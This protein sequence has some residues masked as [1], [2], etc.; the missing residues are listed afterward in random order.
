MV[1]E[2][3][4]ITGKIL[5]RILGNLKR[6]PEDAA[7]ELNIPVEKI[8]SIIKGEKEL[9]FELVERACKIWPVNIGDFYPIRDDCP[10]G[11]KFM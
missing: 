11:V 6:R 2:E 5:L 10:S 3:Q 4:F 1:N 7:R 9:P 8:N